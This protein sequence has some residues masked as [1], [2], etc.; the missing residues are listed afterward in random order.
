MS[1][2]EWWDTTKPAATPDTFAGWEASCRQAWDAATRAERRRCAALCATTRFSGNTFPVH[3][4]EQLRI[5]IAAEIL[6]EPT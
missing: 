2:D 5:D 3:Q 4:M 1:Y 6:K